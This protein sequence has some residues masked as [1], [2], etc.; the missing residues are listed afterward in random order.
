MPNFVIAGLT[1]N[2]YSNQQNEKLRLSI[3]MKRSFYK[4]GI[5]L[6]LHSVFEKIASFTFTFLPV[7]PHTVWLWRLLLINTSFY[8]KSPLPWSDAIE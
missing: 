3:L 8:V 7:H 6:K 4:T 5:R 2:L 1:S